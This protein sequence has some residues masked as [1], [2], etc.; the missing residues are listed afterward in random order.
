[1]LSVAFDDD[2]IIGASTCLPMVDAAPEIRAPLEAKGL[3]PNQYFYFGESVLLN[4]YRGLGLGVKFF[5]AREAHALKDA[6]C[7]HALF[8]AVRRAVD[9]P[10]RPREAKALDEFWR[11]RG[12]C[13]VPG[14]YCQMSWREVGMASEITHTLDAW[15]KPLKPTP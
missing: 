2:T 15:C 9:H 4:A 13:P 8:Y 14:L 3:D 7:D 1:M 10:S 5:A 11:K 6:V 12:Y